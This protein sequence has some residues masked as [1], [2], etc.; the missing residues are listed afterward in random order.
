MEVILHS[1][2]CKRQ[3][4][5]ISVVTYK[6]AIKVLIDFF[7]IITLAHNGI[8][9]IKMLQNLFLFFI[10]LLFNAVRLINLTENKV[11]F[12]VFMISLNATESFY[13][14]LEIFERKILRMERILI[15]LR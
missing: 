6:A 11:F 2:Q 15:C 5:L 8:R 12:Y 14:N 1:I 4:E 10:P 7:P 13:K 3:I 9:H